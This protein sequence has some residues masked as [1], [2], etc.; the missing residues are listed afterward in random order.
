MLMCLIDGTPGASDR[1][2]LRGGSKNPA[3]EAPI[4]FERVRYGNRLLR[5]QIKFESTSP[6]SAHSLRYA[7]VSSFRE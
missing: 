3:P 5:A 2:R 1:S 6:T 4:D 7:I